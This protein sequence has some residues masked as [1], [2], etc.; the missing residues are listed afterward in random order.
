M[1][2][3]IQTIPDLAETLKPLDEVINNKLIPAIT[4]GQ[5]ISAADRSLPIYQEEYTKECRNSRKVTM[6]CWER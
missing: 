3:F 5:I 4:E 2:Y 6:Y 1:T